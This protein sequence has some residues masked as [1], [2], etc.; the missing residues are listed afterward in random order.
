MIQNIVVFFHFLVSILIVILIIL[1]GRSSGF[2]TLFGGGSF[3]STR[4]GSEKFLHQL[5]IVCVII[6]C[7]LGLYRVLGI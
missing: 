6:F 2:S 1:Q 4:R 3:Q 5:T 7:L